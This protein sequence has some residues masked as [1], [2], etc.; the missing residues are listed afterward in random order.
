MVKDTWCPRATYLRI[1]N[2]KTPRTKHRFRTLNVFDHGH[3]IHDLWQTR[4]WDMELLAGTFHCDACGWRRDNVC[5]PFMCPNCARDKDVLRYDEVPLVNKPLM[6]HGHADGYIPDLHRLIE[7]KTVGEG[8]VRMED[9]ERFER[10][11]H[12][13]ESGSLLDAK[14]LWSSLNH[15]LASHIRQGL[16][17]CHLA[18]EQGLDVEGIEYIYDS[19]FT[20]DTKGFYLRANTARIQPLLDEAEVV[21]KA[22]RGERRPP[23]CMWADCKECAP[24]D[25]PKESPD[26]A[27]APRRRDTSG[28]DP[29]GPWPAP[30]GEADGGACGDS[31][32]PDAAQGS[33]AGGADERRA[34]MVR[35][36]RSGAGKS[37]GRRTGK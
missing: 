28:E 18:R 34:R 27:T 7:I 32:G 14:K 35:V 5:S 13:C 9:P 6:I 11:Q 2:G 36:R 24:F 19:K 1:K 10:A 33:R 30:P 23:Q 15:P 31:E 12:T 29:F 20:S 16:L 22:L 4:A 8:S 17:Y 25:N 37:V 26:G 21:A 3:R